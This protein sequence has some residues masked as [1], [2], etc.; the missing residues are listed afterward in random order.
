MSS[1]KSISTSLSSGAKFSKEDGCAK[2]NGQIYKSI[3]SSLLHLS[4]T[5][6]VI[7]FATWL[8]SRSMQNPFEFHFIAIKRILRYAQGSLDF[9]LVY[10]K[11]ESSQLVGYCDSDWAG[12][13]MVQKA[14]VEVVAQ[15]SA[16]VEYIACA[17]ASNHVVWLRK[18]MTN[19]EFKQVKGTLLY[20][21]NQT[22]VAIAK[23]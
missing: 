5:R 16:K 2:A 20:V 13:L 21:D 11:K 6:P 15:S 12:L 10:K 3:T 17:I 9:G 8:M 19:L 23:N 1:C 22:T 4:T 7:M 14:Q 18:V